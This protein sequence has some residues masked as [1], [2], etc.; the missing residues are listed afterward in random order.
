MAPLGSRQ[1]LRLRLLWILVV[2][3]VLGGWLACPPTAEAI[4]PAWSPF[5][6]QPSKVCQLAD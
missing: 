6:S 2:L 5:Q 3:L 4:R 1:R